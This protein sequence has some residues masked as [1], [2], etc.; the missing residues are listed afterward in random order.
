MTQSDLASSL[1]YKQERFQSKVLLEREK[2]KTILFTFY[3]G[4][5]LKEHKANCDVLI[6]LL[7]GACDFMMEQKWQRLQ[8]GQV[9]LIPAHETHGL[10]AVTN[11]KMILIK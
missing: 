3:A 7:E 8:A 1:D 11:F 10:K 9:L 2:Q 5:Q 6:I 4:Q